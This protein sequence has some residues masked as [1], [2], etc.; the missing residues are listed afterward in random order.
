MIRARTSEISEV[1]GF[2]GITLNA[3]GPRLISST[4]AGR[5]GGDHKY[6]WYGAESLD[7]S[8]LWIIN[9]YNIWYWWEGGQERC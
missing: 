7:R 4:L 2:P 3:P 5:E 8:L 9:V 6:P 1:M